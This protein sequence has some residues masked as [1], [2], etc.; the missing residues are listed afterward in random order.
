MNSDNYEFAKSSYPQ[1]VS[2]YTN[3]TDKQWNYLSDINSQVYSNNSGLTLVTWDLTSVYSAGGL[4]DISDLYLAIPVVTC[5]VVSSAAGVA[6]VAPTAGYGLCSLKSNYQN[7]IH[8]IEIV[9]NG[10][11]VNDM[12]PFANVIKNFQLLSQLSATDLK[13]LCPTL[14]V[15]ECLDN[16]KS[17]KWAT[18]VPTATVSQPGIGLCN[19]RPFSGVSGS[20]PLNGTGVAATTPATTNVTAVNPPLPGMQ[21]PSQNANQYNTAI[22]NRISRIADLSPIAGVAGTAN[23]NSNGY[24]GISL[25]ASGSVPYLLSSS[26]LNSEYKPYYTVASNNVMVWYDTAI[27]PLKYI[28]DC[29]DKMGL[30]KKMDIGMR[31]YFNTGT[32]QTTMINTNGASNQTSYGAYTTNF[33]N[34]CPLTINYLTGSAANGGFTN[35]TDALITAGVFIQ[36]PPPTFGTTTVIGLGNT[37]TISSHPMP[38][39]RCY[40]SMIKLDPQRMLTYVEENRSKQIVYENFLFNQY[41]A[42]GL[43]ATF[44]QL[45]Q[46]GIKNPIGVAIIPFIAASQLNVIGTG[47]ALG[48]QFASPYDTCPATYS[49]LSITNLSV[50]LG[51]VN[52]MN[53]SM[54][55]TFENFLEQVSLSESLTSSDIGISVGLINQSFWE[56]NRVYFVD[57][58]RGR[59]ADKETQRNMSVSFNNNSG[60]IIDV[61]IFTLY[62]D[63]FVIDIETGIVTK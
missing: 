56:Q 24:Y 35:A 27:I 29:I 63:K 47:T 2:E 37:Y 12:Q 17:V 7:L 54:F 11:V 15:N 20:V 44:S 58:S 48:S 38:S 40:Y 10:K 36:K 60:V 25:T 9:A 16:E 31:I 14:N 5:A 52:V 43:G 21:V 51:G 22:Y 18:A 42:I 39:C 4:C 26:Q 28:C 46:S 53:T 30:V 33:A 19:N 61:M 41:S 59:Q 8:Q 55:Y 1:S 57:L 49:P 50:N 62:L 3:Y 45:V 23:T 13:A 6:A 34:T 32:V